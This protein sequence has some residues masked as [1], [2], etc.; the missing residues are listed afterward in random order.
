M[1]THAAS[2]LRPAFGTL[3]AIDAQAEDAL[4]VGRGI[5]AAFEVISNIERLMHPSRAGSDLALLAACLPGHCVPVHAWTWE[6][7]QLC[8]QF[9]SSSLGIFDPCL[10]TAAGRITDV[11]LLTDGRVR[12]R[13]PLRVDL[14]GIAKGYA[15]DRAMQALRDAGC[16]AGLVN[17]GGDLAVFG[18][19]SR[20]IVCRAPHALDRVI[21]LRDAALATSAVANPSR[22]PEHRGYYHG[23]HRTLPEFGQV[24]VIAAS[25]AVADALTKCLLFADADLRRKLLQR[26]D[27]TELTRQNATPSPRSNRL[28]SGLSA[29]H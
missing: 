9:N 11:D 10:D 21:Q 16:D 6:V 27:A 18:T 8:Q 23:V 17:A 1:T 25:A 7:L 13:A 5:A 20:D 12:P 28:K 22:P 26:F 19:R 14:G 4:A 2:R 24:T 3:V 29:N 15:V